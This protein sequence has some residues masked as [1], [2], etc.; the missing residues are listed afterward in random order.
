MIDSLGIEL[1]VSENTDAI[2]KIVELSLFLGLKHW[3]L[4]FFL[5][6]IMTLDQ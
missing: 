2:Q 3:F 6:N 4:S 5:V 1:G